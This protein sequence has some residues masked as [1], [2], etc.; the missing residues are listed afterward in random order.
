MTSER[1]ARA[2]QWFPTSKRHS[3]TRR[4]STTATT[5]SSRA[6]SSFLRDG[7]A[8]GEPA[9]V[10][11]SAAKIARLREELGADAA[12]RALRRH[13]GRGSQPGADHPGLARVRRPA[14]RAGRD[15]A[16][17]RRADLRRAQRGRA[18]RV[19]A[20]RG[21]AQPRLRRRRCVLARCARTT[22]GA[23]RRRDRR[24][25]P[26]PPVR[27]RARPPRR[28]PRLRGPRRDR[29]AVRDAAPRTASERRRAPARASRGSARCATSSPSAPR[30]SASTRP[31]L[32]LRARRQRDRDQQP[33]ARHRRASLRLWQNGSAIVCRDPRRGPLRRPARRTRARPRSTTRAAA[34][35]GSRTSSATW[36]RSARR[37]T[38]PPCAC[39]S[40]S[41]PAV[42][43][44]PT[45][46]LTSA[47]TTGARPANVS[48]RPA[49]A[50]PTTSPRLRPARGEASPAGWRP[51]RSAFPFTGSRV[52]DTPS[53]GLAGAPRERLDRTG[54]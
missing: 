34:A 20:P 16:R 52:R 14:R 21:A 43:G 11:V 54:G 22:R 46:G 28:E 4:S 37:R 27:R 35:S 24:G 36:C 42:G 23:R 40:P 32:R 29:R 13:G 51:W 25:P 10:V 15:A 47:V 41:E 31:P 48:G 30:S 7:V 8:R 53:G 38:A 26:Q 19:P 2:T 45:P 18:R 44:K 1:E 50:G 39:T 6:T 33:R 3:V 12:R 9:L 17:D 5:S 49:A